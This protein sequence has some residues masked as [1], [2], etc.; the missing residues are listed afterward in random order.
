MKTIEARV[1]VLAA[2]LYTAVLVKCEKRLTKKQYKLSDKFDK[3]VS[4]AASLKEYAKTVE[5]QSK[6]LSRK[7]VEDFKDAT[8]ELF[9][10]ITE[11]GNRL[12]N[13]K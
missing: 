11:V 3:D 8:D 12:L 7:A 4:E 10:S 6:R 2:K 9:E 5:A 1:A 13:I